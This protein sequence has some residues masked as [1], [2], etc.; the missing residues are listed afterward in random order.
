MSPFFQS[1]SLK[2]SYF[3]F[4]KEWE[5]SSLIRVKT[6]GSTG[7]AKE[8]CFSQKQMLV[9]ALKTIHF[10]DLIPESKALLCLSMDTIAGKMMIVR[11]MVGKWNLIICEPTANPLK[12]LNEDYDFAAFVPL[13]IQKIL[14]ENPEK[15]KR[16]KTIIVGGSPISNELI[17]KLKTN[18]ITVYQTFGMTETVSHI[19][20]R[21]IGKNS[22]Q[23]YTTLNGISVSESN[24][25]LA[26]SYPEM[27][28][29]E[30]VTNDI[31]QIISSDKF[32]WLG[33]ADF[34]INSG[35]I[36][37][38]PELLENKLSL[39]YSF[40]FFLTGLPDEILGSKLAL[41][42]EKQDELFVS[43]NELLN[44]LEKFEIPKVYV[45]LD[46]FIRTES[47]KINR[48]QTLNKIESTQWNTIH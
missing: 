31:V 30:L 18:D 4:I 8:I 32:E 37:M 34:I 7:E 42:I 14:D 33:R 20:L 21:K 1:D 41:V 38:N 3:N 24:S 40:P 16:I 23:Y 19:A 28:N 39:L 12:Y 22:E 17:E 47:G 25:Q 43:K 2:L 44:F 27:F 6:S 15:L 11:S 45:V 26:I 29:Q 5:T 13:Q 48:I 10:F 9:S 46:S 35:G 36:K